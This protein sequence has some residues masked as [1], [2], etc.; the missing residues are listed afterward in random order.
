MA[1]EHGGTHHERLLLG[2]TTKRAVVGLMFS[3]FLTVRGLTTVTPDAIT[4]KDLLVRHET[5]PHLS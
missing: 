4:G 5:D 1:A 3:I 2:C